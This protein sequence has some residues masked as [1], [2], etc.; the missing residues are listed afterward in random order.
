MVG[1]IGLG[2]PP[3]PL[4]PVPEFP[5]ELARR[6]ERVLFALPASAWS[7]ESSSCV[8][9]SETAMYHSMI[10]PALRG[11]MPVHAIPLQD[12]FKI[13]VYRTQVWKVDSSCRVIGEPRLEEPILKI[14]RAGFEY[15]FQNERI[16]RLYA[17]LVA[18]VGTPNVPDAGRRVT[19][20]RG[21][22]DLD[23]LITPP[24]GPMFFG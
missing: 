1:G 22:R 2:I 14:T 7:Y 19:H 8:P 9:G 5:V 24:R 4:E 10:I 15:R 3:T 20:E 17:S 21:L 6:F 18:T 13:S 12:A 11:V 16:S 23:H